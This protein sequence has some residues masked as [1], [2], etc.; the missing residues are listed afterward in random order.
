MTDYFAPVGLRPPKK[1][2]LMITNECNLQCCHCWTDSLPSTSTT[3]VPLDSIVKLIQ[4]LGQLE[5]EEICLTG[6]EPLTHP[7]LFEILSFACKQPGLKKVCLQTN[8]TLLSELEIKA[9]QSLHYDGLS[10]Q[11]SIEGARAQTHDWVRGAGSF[12]RSFYGLTLLAEAGLGKQTLVT[13]TEMEHNFMELPLLL[14]MV[15]QLGIG[16][17]ISGTL[18]LGGRAAKTKQIAPPRPSQYKKLL[19]L[20]HGGTA[21]RSRYKKIGNIAALEWYSGRSNSVPRGCICAET[22][23]INAAGR[24][25]PCVMLPVDK[26]GIDGVYHRSFEE[27]F[28]EAALHWAELPGLYLKRASELEVCK[29][30]VGRFHCAGGCMGRAYALNGDF[31]TVE[32]R[33]AL[34]KSVYSWKEQ[35]NSASAC[36]KGFYHV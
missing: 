24:M 5:V 15:D 10:I 22:P 1:M 34:R 35:E 23:Y 17:L 31:M 25:F 32:D 14:K 11:V 2:T 36:D 30:C 28:M 9:L 12:K 29:E 7:Q 6:G 8:A 27:I 18:V 19:A 16:G 4:V 26:Y 33:C 21:F 13:F 20:F 3:Q